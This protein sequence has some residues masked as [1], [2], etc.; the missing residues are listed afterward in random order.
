MN[1]IQTKGI[2]GVQTIPGSRADRVRCRRRTRLALRTGAAVVLATMLVVACTPAR[3]PTLS[4][5]PLGRTAGAACA[6]PGVEF[7]KAAPQSVDMRP[8]VLKKALVLAAGTNAQTV[9][10]FRH[11]CLVATG[12]TSQPNLEIPVNV[13]SVTKAVVS[14]LVGH[15]YTLGKLGLDD[16]IGKYLPEAD[17]AHG[18]ITVRQLLTET[19]GLSFAWLNDLLANSSNAV[20]FELS[21][22]FAHTP[23]T[24]FEYAQQ[25]ITLLAKVVERAVGQDF[26][27]FAR[28]QLFHKIGIPD[29]HWSWERD[30]AG[31]TFGYAFLSI[32]PIDLARLGL[33]VLHH[34]KW[35]GRT[36]ISAGYIRQGATPTSTN[37]GYGFLWW[38]NTGGSVITPEPYRQELQRSIIPSMPADTFSFDGL[39]DQ[40]VV[41]VPSLDMVVVRTGISGNKSGDFLQNLT[42]PGDGIS[43]SFKALGKSIK[44]VKVA[45]PGPW[46]PDPVIP[47]NG[48]SLFNL[49][50]PTRG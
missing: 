22:P 32:A 8:T 41:M 6:D 5:N 31:N 17:A 1:G 3:P 39:L 24:Y 2:Y 28:T 50:L 49:F 19:S 12:G 44:D 9:A 25:T 14:T 20:N 10:V 35:N 48:A 7:E 43:D 15:A 33:L 13:W 46:V 29:N 42:I 26:Q 34:G 45:D 4:E 40:L 36:L 27:A 37:P 21:L 16:P 23:G 30:A 38:T 18:A 47:L 11:G